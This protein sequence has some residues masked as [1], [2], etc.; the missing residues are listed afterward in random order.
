M[1]LLSGVNYFS[2]SATII[3]PV[4]DNY[5]LCKVAFFSYTDCGRGRG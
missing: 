3:L 5:K 2:R 1:P 4:D